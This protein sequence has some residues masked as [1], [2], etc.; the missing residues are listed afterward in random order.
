[1]VHYVKS[2]NDRIAGWYATDTGTVPAEWV[3]RDS[4]SGP[5]VTHD[6]VWGPFATELA[7]RDFL[8]SMVDDRMID[9]DGRPTDDPVRGHSADD[10]D[11]YDQMDR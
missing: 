3:W 6:Q 11:A 5:E 8:Q 10:L 2:S 4:G 9:R 7:A 1:M